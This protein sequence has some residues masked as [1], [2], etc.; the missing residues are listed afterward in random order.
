MPYQVEGTARGDGRH[1]A[2]VWLVM[3]D[4]ELVC[5]W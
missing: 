2:S 5:G 1:R 4:T 3:A